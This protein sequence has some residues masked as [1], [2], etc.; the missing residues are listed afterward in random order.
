MVLFTSENSD[1]ANRRVDESFFTMTN[2]LTSLALKRL[3]YLIFILK[4]EVIYCRLLWVAC[5]PN[6]I[7]AITNACAAVIYFG[8]YLIF[9][10]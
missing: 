4:L 10:F 1:I 9:C 8:A 7:V 5:N 2:Q 3:F 6:L